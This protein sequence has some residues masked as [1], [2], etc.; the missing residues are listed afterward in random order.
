[1]RGFDSARL[2]TRRAATQLPTRVGVNSE[3]GTAAATYDS[4]R[5]GARCLHGA[6]FG[7]GP[8][9]SHK[10]AM[11]PRFGTV[12][13]LSGPPQRQPPITRAREECEGVAPCAGGQAQGRDAGMGP[14]SAS[15]LGRLVWLSQGSAHAPS[16]LR[17][18]GPVPA[19]AQG[20][21]GGPALRGLRRDGRPAAST[22]PGK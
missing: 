10:R 17:A 6:R 19:R 18:L 5:D 22:G 14:L 21:L 15:E 20:A 9:G 11:M 4:G 16:H 1:M 12:A 8:A 13:A 2:A 7:P 3:R